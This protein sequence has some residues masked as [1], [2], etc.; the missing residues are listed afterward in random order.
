MGHN[1]DHSE[2]PPQPPLA[3][4]DFLERLYPENSLEREA[5][6]RA[7][8]T[9]N[10]EFIDKQ[11]AS[12][13]AFLADEQVLKLVAWRVADFTPE[14]TEIIRLILYQYRQGLNYQEVGQNLIDAGIVGDKTKFR[15]YDAL[16]RKFAESALL[17]E[18]VRAPSPSPRPAGALALYFA[19][20]EEARR[21][22][23][24]PKNE[25]MHL[26]T[27][28]LIDYDPAQ[29]PRTSRQ[30]LTEIVALCAM[31]KDERAS[32]H[33][34]LDHPQ[35]TALSEA[36]YEHFMGKPPEPAP[37]SIRQLR[38]VLEVMGKTYNHIRSARHQ[39]QVPMPE[40]EKIMH[41][42]FGNKLSGAAPPNRE[43]YNHRHGLQNAGPSITGVIDEGIRTGLCDISAYLRYQIG[44]YDT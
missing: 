11:Y 27:R 16:L 37:A 22:S 30:A 12:F 29:D 14:N 26:H 20:P 42:F 41:F 43:I 28:W 5:L 31:P 13:E 18:S 6:E 38:A 1:D 39:D 15:S 44:R 9:D 23:K 34:Y 3:N 40:V 24:L 8:Q 17:M 35:I 19:A 33:E 4:V 7:K 2:V 36:A 10:H 21:R 32:Y 25:A